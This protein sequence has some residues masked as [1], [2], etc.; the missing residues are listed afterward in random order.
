MDQAMVTLGGG[1]VQGGGVLSGPEANGATANLVDPS[2]PQPMTWPPEEW[3][4]ITDD[5]RKVLS[6]SSHPVNSQWPRAADTVCQWKLEALSSE[7]VLEEVSWVSCHG[8]KCTGTH[9]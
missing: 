2:K 6:C 7:G 1:G 5:L 9:E 8:Q 3:T 4:I